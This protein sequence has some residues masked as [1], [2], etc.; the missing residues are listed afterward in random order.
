MF[1]AF[2]ENFLNFLLINVEAS[3]RAYRFLASNSK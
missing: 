1:F 3:K 2:G